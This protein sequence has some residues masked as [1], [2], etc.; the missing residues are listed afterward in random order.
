MFE[1]Q[2]LALIVHTSILITRFVSLIIGGLLKNAYIALG[3]F[4]ASGVLVYGGLA[5][6]NLILAK[7]SFRTILLVLMK[8]GAIAAIPLGLVLAIKTLA[9][10]SPW[11]VVLASVTAGF[12]Y[13]LLILGDMLSWKFDSLPAVFLPARKIRRFIRTHLVD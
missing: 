7:L 3:L 12:L 8:Y 10:G 6:W 11:M 9:A 4:S 13:Y 2:E 1:K 5:F